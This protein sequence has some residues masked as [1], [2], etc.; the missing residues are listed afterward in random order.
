M[1]DGR[2]F[3]LLQPGGTE[4]LK[5]CR[6][7][8]CHALEGKFQCTA[9]IHN[10]EDGAASSFSRSK[11]PIVP[12]IVYKKQISKNMKLSVW[13]D[14]LTTHKVDA[15]VN[16]ANENLI[17]GAGLALALCQAG[18]RVI[19]EQSYDIIKHKG[20]VFTGD[21]VATLAGNLP[22][23]MIIHA[24]G[25]CVSR[26]P[27]TTELT[28]ASDLLQKTIWNILTKAHFED[29]QSV[30]IPAISSGI[31]N[32]PLRRCADIIVDT[33][34]DFNKKRKPGARFLEV[35][36]VNNDDP[37]VHEM[38]RAC[39][40]ILGSG[41]PLPKQNQVS[42]PT[43]Y[44]FPN[45]D[46]GNMTLYLKKGAIE[47][48]TTDVIVD[49]VGSDLTLSRGQVSNAL[50]Q[51]AGHK[52]QNE[53]RS[54][55]RQYTFEGE[56]LATSGWNLSCKKV[57]HIV[58][59]ATSSPDWIL[60]NALKECLRKA[61]TDGYKSI[62]F[63][64]LGTGNLGLPKDKVS[65]FMT[66]SV[67][68]FA[69]TYT[70]KK[71]QIFFVIFPKDTET[72]KAFE[73]E[74]DSRRKLQSAQTSRSTNDKS[75]SLHDSPELRKTPCIEVFAPSPEALTEAKSWSYRILSPTLTCL[76]IYNNNI[77]HLSQKD[78][79][80]LMI[81]QNRF[82]VLITEFFKE[83]R[84]GIIINGGS[85]GVSCAAL[86]VESM[87]CQAQKD[88]VQSEEKEMLGN[89][90]DLGQG[91]QFE[92]MSNKL[93]QK[94][95]LNEWE[96]KEKMKNFEKHGLKVVKVERIENL[97][98]KELF[99][100]NCKRIQAKPKQLY[101]RVNTQFCDSIC[102]V[103]FQREYAPPKEQKYGAGIYFTSDLNHA[104]FLW[105]DNEDEYVYYIEAQVLTGKDKVGS[106]DLIVPPSIGTDP[107]V[108]YDSVT[109]GRDI[110]VIFNGQRAYPEFLITCKKQNNAT[111]C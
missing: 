27:T 86:E 35:R 50:L 65:Q 10:L 91:Q 81:L 107:L 103:G 47:K 45:L 59:D 95:P 84:G 51:N 93:Y 57:Y 29:L 22:C 20:K 40:E 99:E 53:I 97:A 49:T 68:E 83:G 79:E 76:K 48:E 2:T 43:Q 71:M 55:K 104:S 101:Q 6:A 109:N 54:V 108:R 23:K 21:V 111:Y 100:L 28:K 13:K 17:H 77:M 14:D 60:H 24:V 5:K 64:A 4:V 74:I 44:P 34:K 39:L 96:S 46:L 30:A 92:R 25:P 88:F 82:N 42:V 105:P 19:Q 36:L 12:E 52:M 94:I 102:R 33:V 18:G 87:L 89:M 72:L 70:G 38:Q 58:C 9:E 3:V 32:F 69:K 37:S 66:R 98:L 56:I 106:S 16:A 11:A 61:T 8:F 7:A 75:P 1:E 85:V 78:H 41:D 15:V 110:Y 26:S 80:K 62:S 31:F 73:K 63:P 90:D 67:M